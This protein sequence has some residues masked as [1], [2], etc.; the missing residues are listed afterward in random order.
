M[1]AC[2]QSALAFVDAHATLEAGRHGIPPMA[3]ST[4]LK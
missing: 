4:D 3:P 2:S 1:W